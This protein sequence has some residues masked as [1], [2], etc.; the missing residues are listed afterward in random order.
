M[1]AVSKRY[2][3]DEVT[4]PQIDLADT[5]K[6][7]DEFGDLIRYMAQRFASRLPPYLDVDDLVHSGVIGLI[8]AIG[9][10]DASRGTRFKTYAEFRIRGAMLDEMRAM[11]WVPRSVHEK[12]KLLQN[13]LR[14]LENNLGRAPTQ[15]EVIEELQM[16]QD[17]YDAFLYQARPVALLSFENFGFNEGDK[18][19]ALELLADPN[20]EDP[21]LDLL[22]QD[23]HESLLDAIKTLPER[24][25]LVVSLY[26]QEDLTMKEVG[27][28]LRITESRVCQLHTQ[29]VLRMKGKLENAEREGSKQNSDGVNEQSG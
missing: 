6:L 7:I 13:A 5:E 25:Q 18:R 3:S 19:N 16:D 8:D 1:M 26:Y 10:F 17:Q 12:I 23:T 9:K 24:E 28:I 21:L 27:K 11:D 4:S 2:I 22:S 20:A 14:S 15:E 29:A